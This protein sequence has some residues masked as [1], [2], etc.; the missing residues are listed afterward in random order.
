MAARSVFLRFG[1]R[2][3]SMNDLAEAA[4][5]SRAA[6][7]LAFKNKEDVFL[8]VFLQFVD[9][10]IADIEREMATCV[11]AQAKL[12]SAFELWAVR[13]FELTMKSA[14]AREL[15]EC[16]FDF[17][18]SSLRDGYE[19]FEATIVPVLTPLAERRPARAHMDPERIAH[20]LASAVRGFKQTAATPD[21]LRLLIEDLLTLSLGDDE[22]SRRNVHL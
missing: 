18:E 2:R 12:T 7:Y 11:T 14:E 5:I 13:P 22:P 8:G 4:G 17:A 3:V 6:L 15:V 10:T 9:E 16:S 19:R 21:A 1:Y 20:V